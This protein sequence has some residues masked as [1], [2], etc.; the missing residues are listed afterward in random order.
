MTVAVHGVGSMGGAILDGLRASGG[1]VIAVVRREDQ[2]ERLRADGVRVLA[3][4]DA[5]AEATVH[6]I[7]VK[8]PAVRSL[9]E[10]LAPGLTPG[11]VVVSV[12]L[13]V[14]LTDL[15]E[16]LPDSVVAVRAMPNTPSQVGEGM[17]VLSL[18]ETATQAQRQQVVE[19]FDALGRTI[20]I[21]E[22]QQDVAT[23][24]SG[25]SPAYFFLIA[26][27]MIDAGVAQGMPRETAR[28]LVTQ[29]LKGAGALL[30]SEEAEPALLRAQVTSP[31]GSTAA[32]LAALEQGGIRS[33]M[34]AAIRACTE[35]SAG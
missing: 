30:A 24:L 29:A 27:A 9:L 17:T 1:E 35:R 11:S 26:E 18:S 14:S 25:S 10:D 34:A 4:A 21:P 20:T 28:T 5:A 23:A 7:A 31:G 8:P 33:T 15:E 22:S 6:V 32:A 19:V 2:A 3:A 13:G 16:V 12:A